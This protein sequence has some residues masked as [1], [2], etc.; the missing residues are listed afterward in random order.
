MILALLVFGGYWAIPAISLFNRR[1][2]QFKE[3]KTNVI[4][5]CF[6]HLP[7]TCGIPVARTVRRNQHQAKTSTPRGSLRD[8]RPNINI[9]WLANILRIC[10]VWRIFVRWCFF[11]YLCIFLQW[12]N[13]HCCSCPFNEGA[14]NDSKKSG[15]SPSCLSK[16]SIQDLAVAPN[17]PKSSKFIYISP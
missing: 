10:Y 1:T 6:H 14:K 5:L 17:L 7:P 3:E 13:W 15:F 2:P 8:R 12:A 9:D 16:K 11:V 4:L